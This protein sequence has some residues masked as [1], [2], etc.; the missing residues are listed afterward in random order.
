MNR[1]FLLHLWRYRNVRLSNE[2]FEWIVS[3]E[4]VKRNYSYPSGFRLFEISN[5]FIFARASSSRSVHILKG[6]AIYPVGSCQKNR[7]GS[8]HL[9]VSFGM[10]WL[11][12][13]CYPCYVFSNNMATRSPRHAASHSH[14]TL[15]FIYIVTSI[16]LY[17]FIPLQLI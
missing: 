2:L 14:M 8:I 9:L 13:T 11:T 15:F 1:L 4:V 16:F 5:I 7:V 12:T 17:L 10:M 6:F 3:R